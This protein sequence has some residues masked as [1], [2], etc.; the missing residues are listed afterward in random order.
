MQWDFQ[1]EVNIKHDMQYAFQRGLQTKTNW[2]G[3]HDLVGGILKS[4]ATGEFF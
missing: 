3:K 2:A 1:P 4:S